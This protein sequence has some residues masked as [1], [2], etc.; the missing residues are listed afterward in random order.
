MEELKKMQRV[1]SRQ[2]VDSQR[3]LLTIDA[4]TGQ[5]GLFQARA[6]TEA[7]DCEGVLLAKVD[8]SSKGGV[9]FAIA[10]DNSTSPSLFIGTGEQPDDLAPFDPESF[11][12][13]L[14]TDPDQ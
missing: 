8:S 6:F 14:F 2:G 12:E 3:V 4:T 7:V 11:V 10:A 1:L 9:V 5:N 13:S